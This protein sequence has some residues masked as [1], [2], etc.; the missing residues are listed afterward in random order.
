MGPNYN[1]TR[2]RLRMESGTSLEVSRIKGLEKKSRHWTSDSEYD[3][4]YIKVVLELV[5]PSLAILSHVL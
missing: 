3:I 5:L 1:K 4:V 2:S